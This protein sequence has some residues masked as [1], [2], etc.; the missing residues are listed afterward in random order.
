MPTPVAARRSHGALMNRTPPM[1]AGTPL[2]IA[3]QSH[4]ADSVPMASD[5][6]RRAGDAVEQR[7]DDHQ[8]DDVAQAPQATV[9]L[10][11]V[12]DPIPDPVMPAEHV[13]GVREH[14]RDHL[15]DG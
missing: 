8:V 11:Y 12:C 5:P 14:R 3:H 1:N 4:S 2:M 15:R 10:G 9:A 6:Q 7:E 13:A